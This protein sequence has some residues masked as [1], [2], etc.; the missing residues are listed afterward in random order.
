MPARRPYH[1]G[2]LRRAVVGAALEE[3]AARG[4]AVLSMREVA[5][6]AG[7]SHAA[8]A[9]H[10]GDRKGVFT[11]IAAEGFRMLHEAT[12]QVTRDA[13][14]LSGIGLAYIR[15]ALAH[16]AHFEVMFRPE[17]LHLDDEELL[18][19]RGRAFEIFY[20]TVR[21]SLGQPDEERFKGAAIAAWA[22]VHG[23]ASL[24]L[25]RA[26]PLEFGDDADTLALLT[27]SGLVDIGRVIEPLLGA[28]TE[29]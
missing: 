14:A 10:F 29:L 7:V 13:G 2:D 20:A 4:P 25:S 27:A 5:R 8:P 6:R 24:W 28:G 19:E 23:F 26:L 21:A 9:H 15:F 12:A 22:V 18:S 1:H 11:A 16:P 3:I 17:L